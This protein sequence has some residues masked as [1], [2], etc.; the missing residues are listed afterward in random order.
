[1]QVLVELIAGL[2]ALLAALVLSQ[3]GVDIHAP[4]SSVRQSWTR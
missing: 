1:M 2:V 3:F 4:A